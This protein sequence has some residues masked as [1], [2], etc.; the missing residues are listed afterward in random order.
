[1]FK[2]DYRGAG[3]EFS[4]DVL[5]TRVPAENILKGDG[6][7]KLGLPGIARYARLPAWVT[8]SLSGLEVVADGERHLTDEC[9]RIAGKMDVLAGGDRHPFS[10][11]DLTKSGQLF[12]RTALLSC[13]YGRPA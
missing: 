8:E 1:M 11:V 9:T 12:T 7:R 5:A 10:A 2:S 4:G 13:F 3:Q 6:G